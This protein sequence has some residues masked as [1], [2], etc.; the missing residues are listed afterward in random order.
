[1]DTF[2]EVIDKD[3]SDYK[4][5]GLTNKLN[6]RNA[7]VYANIINDNPSNIYLVEKKP[8]NVRIFR[9]LNYPGHRYLFLNKE[10]V[11]ALE[12]TNLADNIDSFKEFLN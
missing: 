7:K 3:F 6:T 12:N 8:T 4:L 1:M 10:K 11:F 5:I 2:R 9:D